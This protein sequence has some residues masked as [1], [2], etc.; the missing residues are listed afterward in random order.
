MN[1]KDCVSPQLS[2]ETVVRVMTRTL[3]LINREK[4]FKHRIKLASNKSVVFW[5]RPYSDLHIVSVLGSSTRYDSI[6]DDG[7]SDR[8]TV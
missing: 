4:K 6:N 7:G 2:I 5:H 1:W 3:G 8:D